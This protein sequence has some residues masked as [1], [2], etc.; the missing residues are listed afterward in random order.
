MRRPLVSVDTS[1]DRRWLEEEARHDPIRHAYARW[2]LDH[3]PTEVEFRVHLSGGVPTAYL[4]IWLGLRGVPVVHWV[5]DPG[6]RELLP[7]LP[8]RPL[9]AVVPE[10]LAAEV[11]DAR[12]PAE[13]HPILILHRPPATPLPAP[14]TAAVRRL[15]VDDLPSL[16]ALARDDEPLARAYVATDPTAEPVWGAFDGARL[17]GVSRTQARLPD[18][19]IVGGIYVQA[20]YRGRGLGRALTSAAVRAAEAAGAEA[21]LYVREDNPPARRVYDALGFTLFERKIWIDA[22]GGRRP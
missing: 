5:G 22:G 6:A 15:T 17:V 4:L 21:V 11:A 16:R 8:P 9:I 2:D 18:V 7:H 19:W 1:L 14:S 20:E 13:S 10:L 3:H 12:G